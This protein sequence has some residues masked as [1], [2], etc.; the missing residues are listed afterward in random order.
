MAQK[1]Y[2][3]YQRTGPSE[4]MAYITG[5]TGALPFD[6]EGACRDY[7]RSLISPQGVTGANPIEFRPDDTRGTLMVNVIVTTLRRPHA[8]QSRRAGR[9]QEHGRAARQAARDTA[10]GAGRVRMG[11]YPTRELSVDNG[12]GHRLLA[13]CAA[14]WSVRRAQRRIWP[15]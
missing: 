13:T 1:F 12:F 15:A 10:F 2:G 7:Y 6:S 8:A 11:E 14:V 3:Y 5:Q 4:Y 9:P